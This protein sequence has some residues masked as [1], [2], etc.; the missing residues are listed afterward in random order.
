MALIPMTVSRSTSVQED[1]SY[2]AEWQ[3]TNHE[4]QHVAIHGA[5][6]SS[7]HAINSYEPLALSELHTAVERVYPG[8]YA[9]EG[10]S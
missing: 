7:E 6:L 3:I 2:A 8:V 5:V 4:I 9:I 1:G 10:S